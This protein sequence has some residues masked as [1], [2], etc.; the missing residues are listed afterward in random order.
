RSRH[1]ID[2]LIAELAPRPDV[3]S[4]I[5]KLSTPTAETPVPPHPAPPGRASVLPPAA[6]T[7]SPPPLLQPTAPQRYRLQVT[8]GQAAQE[9]LRR[10]QALLRRE[11]PDGDAGRILER[12]LALL[13]AEVEKKKFGGTTLPRDR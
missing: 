1:Q 8:I 7:T 6:R 11:I 10:L 5:R 4:S 3:P 13:L 2:V 12:A 9:Q